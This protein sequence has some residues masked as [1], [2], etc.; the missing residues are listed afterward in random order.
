[1]DI[2]ATV[3]NSWRQTF[4]GQKKLAEGAMRQLSEGQL[5]AA[6]APGLN[7]IA[8]IVQHVAGNLSSRFGPGWLEVDG[9]RPSRDRDSEFVDRGLGRAA[10]MELWERGWSDLFAAVDGLRAED[11]SRTV[12]IR[13]EPHTV[14]LSVARALGHCGYHVG[15]ITMIARGVKGSDGWEWLT[16]RPGGTGE[17]NRGKGEAGGP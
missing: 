12:T 3:I 9:E 16:I 17:F 11:L 7:S 4:T 1:M 8:V 5:H 6:L 15:Q 10:L 14:P 13:G 2:Q